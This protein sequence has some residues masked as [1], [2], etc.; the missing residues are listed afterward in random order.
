MDPTTPAMPATAAPA[1]ELVLRDI[2]LPPAPGFWPPAPGWWVLAV[3]LVGLAWWGWRRWQRWQRRRRYARQF[4]QALLVRDPQQRLVAISSLLRRAARQVDR[5]AAQLR[6]EEWLVWLD[7]HLPRKATPAFASGPGRVLVDGL[8]AARVD[9][10]AVLALEGP[11]RQCFLHML[12][13]R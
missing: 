1:A 12:A 3:L 2:H 5:A 9:A 10:Q 8:Y 13:P 11:A 6:G 7:R 4:D